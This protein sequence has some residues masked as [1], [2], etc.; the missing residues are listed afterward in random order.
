MKQNNKPTV[1]AHL[2]DVLGIEVVVKSESNSEGYNKLYFDYVP[3]RHFDGGQVS[4]EAKKISRVFRFENGVVVIVKAANDILSF[5]LSIPKIFYDNTKGLLG[6][7]NGKQED[8][9]L[10]P[11]GT[12][13][14][15]DSTD[16]I[17]FYLF[18]EQ[19]T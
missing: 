14:P 11:D 13:V 8:D 10:R 15:V 6:T 19:C 2:H 3:I 5:Q 17:I 4:V 18:G 1:Q 16:E 9:F 7:W 12:T